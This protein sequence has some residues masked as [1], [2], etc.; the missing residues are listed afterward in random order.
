MT[1]TKANMKEDVS[2]IKYGDFQPVMLV[3][4]GCKLEYVGDKIHGIDLKLSYRE[5]FRQL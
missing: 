4:G 2:P 1:M 5:T 3:I